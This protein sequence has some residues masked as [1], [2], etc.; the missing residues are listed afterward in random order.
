MD[1]ALNALDGDGQI[2]GGDALR[3]GAL[4]VEWVEIGRLFGSPSNPRINEAGVDPVAASLRRFGWRQP[5]VAKPSGEV[6]AGNT[7]LKAAHKLN[8]THV[9]VVWF[10]GTDLEAT[11]YAIADNRTHEFSEWDEPALAKLLQELR[12]EDSLDG[13]GYEASDIDDLLAELDDGSANAEIDDP[14]PEDPPQTPTSRRGDL[15]ILGDH[16]ILCGDSTNADD[17]RRLLGGETAALL[18]TDPPYCV[19]Y[20]GKDRPIHDGKPSGKDWSHVYRE[21]DIKDLGEFLDGVFKA[22]LPHIA[23][24]T[25]IYVWH[26]HV[27]QPTIAAVFARHGLLLHQV[28]IWVKPC[29]VFGHSY[30]RWR[31]EPCAFGWRQ[32]SKPEHGVGQLDTVWEVDWEGK[33]RVVG[34]EHPT[35]KPLRLFEIPMEQHTRRGDLVLEPFSGSGSQLIAA[36][37]LGRRCRAMEISP[38]FVDVAIRRWQKATGKDAVLDGG[39]KTYAEIAEER[40]RGEQDPA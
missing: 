37:R 34:N 38:A 31:H 1:D 35:Q 3:D 6:I 10:E 8:L 33:Q 30:Y 18:S 26:A 15:W 2:N 5:V 39:T 20:T 16:R 24:G 32:G 14:G 25:A 9:P 22:T 19:N 29:A 27:Q 12:A 23:E 11:A 13:V 21:V 28:L 36:E 4:Q 17:V 7:R 40:S